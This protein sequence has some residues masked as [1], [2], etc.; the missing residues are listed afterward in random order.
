MHLALL[1]YFDK[2]FAVAAIAYWWRI[3]GE[4]ES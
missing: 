1:A 2:A 3:G 4:L